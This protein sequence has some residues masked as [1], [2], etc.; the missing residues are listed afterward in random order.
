MISGHGDQ[1]LRDEALT[2]GA[3][4][5]LAKPFDAGHLCGLVREVVQQGQP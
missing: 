2:N 5:F 1:Q 3:V 4:A